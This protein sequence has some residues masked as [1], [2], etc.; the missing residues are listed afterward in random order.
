MKQSVTLQGFT[1]G[2]DHVIAV[3]HFVDGQDQVIL[4]TYI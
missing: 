3:G 2:Q 4:D 1:S